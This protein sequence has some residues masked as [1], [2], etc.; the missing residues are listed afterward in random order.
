MRFLSSVL[1]FIPQM[2]VCIKIKHVNNF[3]LPKDFFGYAAYSSVFPSVLSDST[4]STLVLRL[5]TRI[6]LIFLLFV[7]IREKYFRN[8]NSEPQF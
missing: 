1:Q 5:N 8:I 2:V 3:S 7:F 6:F 4:T